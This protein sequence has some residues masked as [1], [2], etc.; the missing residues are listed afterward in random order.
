[1][2]SI[3]KCAVV[4]FIFIAIGYVLLRI[5]TYYQVMSIKDDLT[6]INMKN[7]VTELSSHEEGKSLYDIYVKKFSNTGLENYIS[8]FNQQKSREAL[9]LERENKKK[10]SPLSEEDFYKVCGFGMKK[11]NDNTIEIYDR[12]KPSLKIIFKLTRKIK[13]HVNSDGKNLHAYPVP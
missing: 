11:N 5:I 2:T 6:I 9:K 4:I 12:F 10:N 1:M 3:L 7:I 13:L 8:L